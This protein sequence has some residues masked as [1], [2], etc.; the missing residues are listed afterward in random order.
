MPALSFNKVTL[1][2]RNNTPQIVDTLITLHQHLE[3]LG[4]QVTT[5]EHTANTLNRSEGISL[6]QLAQHSELLIVIGGDGSILS[7][8]AQAA[9]QGVPVLGINRGRL[10]F[11]ADL[12]PHDLK[13]LT[14]VLHGKYRAETRCLMDASSHQAEQPHTPIGTAL[15]DVVVRGDQV[16]MLEY[17]IYINQ[18]FVCNQRADGLVIATPTGS[19]AYA[20]SAGGPILHPTMDAFVLVPICAHRLNT[21]PLVIDSSSTIDIVLQR[22][23]RAHASVSCDGHIHQHLANNCEVHVAR[24]PQQLQLIHPQDYHYFETLKTKLHWERKTDAKLP[25]NS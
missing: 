25:T 1:M 14:Q 15:N 8:A 11:L 13:S 20:L 4:I 17:D 23:G 9:Q 21:R 6:D 7:S 18:Q 24:H 3:S 10:G 2:A 22:S 19:T 16:H 5:D 12:G